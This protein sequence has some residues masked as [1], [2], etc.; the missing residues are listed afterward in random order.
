MSFVKIGRQQVFNLIEA[1]EL[2]PVVQ[3]ITQQQYDK[4]VHI[5]EQLQRLLM[6]DPRRQHYQRKFRQNITQWKTKIE[7]LGLSVHGLW[8]VQF[9]LGEG[10]L[11]WQ[12]PE[13]SISHFL[14][15]KSQWSQRIKLQDYINNHDPDW[16]Y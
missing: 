12:Y 6:A 1:N 16:A 9:Y 2:L 4:N 13:L 3:K 5:E 14:P 11:C 15:E 10:S 7:G 8:Q